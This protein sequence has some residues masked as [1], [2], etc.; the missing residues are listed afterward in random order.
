MKSA[1][2]FSVTDADQRQEVARQMIR[3]VMDGITDPDRLAAV[4]ISWIRKHPPIKPKS[5][6]AAL[7]AKKR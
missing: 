1:L 4:A 3:A 5:D 6:G 2:Q 7:K